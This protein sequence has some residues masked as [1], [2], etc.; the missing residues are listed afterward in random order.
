MGSVPRSDWTGQLLA[1]TYRVHQ[2]FG[3]SAV[4]ALHQGLD[5]KGRPIVVEIL[6]QPV[7]GPGLDVALDQLNRIRALKHPHICPVIETATLKK[8]PAFLVLD[9][10]DGRTLRL[11]LTR[12][13]RLSI[14][15][16]TAIAHRVLSALD[17]GHRIGVA[18]GRLSPAAVLLSVSPD[19][20]ENVQ[21]LDYGLQAISGAVEPGSQSASYLAPEQ[22]RAGKPDARGDVYSVGVLLYEALLGRLPQ[23]GAQSR[24]A[25][26]LMDGRTDVTQELADLI[27][28]ALAFDPA[29]RIQS[30]GQMR[31]ALSLWAPPVVV[32]GL[33]EQTSVSGAVEVEVSEASISEFLPIGDSIENERTEVTRADNDRE[34]G[35]TEISGLSELPEELTGIPTAIVRPMDLSDLPTL[36][37][38]FPPSGLPGVREEHQEDTGSLP[39]ESFID[40][41]PPISEPPTMAGSPLAMEA[42][43]P[44]VVN[45]AARGSR[46]GISKRAA[47][48]V[49]AMAVFV[50]VVGGA[51]LG[52]LSGRSSSNA[53]SPSRPAHPA[54]TPPRAV[55]APSAVKA[56]ASTA[57]QPAAS[58]TVPALSSP[59]ATVTDPSMDPATVEE[60][61]EE[62][63]R[64]PARWRKRW[65]PR[66][67]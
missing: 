28:K 18:H 41:E 25:D 59:T 60:P 6:Q 54:P 24:H 51:A 12:K 36:P 49:V 48:V 33:D 65:R 43:R 58:A 30:A 47:W 66:R 63:P 29:R 45:R 9:T 61:V 16:A 19:G 44:G 20:I 35:I 2:G 52:I 62:L 23:S 32:L 14:P 8:R 7:L 13:P 46:K 56:N 5:S 15:R 17:A 64:S 40:S 31:D 27:A 34:A 21:V 42:S 22:S 67:R 38:I 37:R 11:Q 1:G 26:A 53:P 50:G 57:V 39:R 55:A 10:A 3:L 4:G